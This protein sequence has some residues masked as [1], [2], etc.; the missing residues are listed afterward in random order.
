[1]MNP[2]LWLFNNVIG[3]YMFF[4]IVQA[5]LSL[6]IMFNIVNRYQPFVQQVSVFLSGITEPAYRRIRR[7]V[8]QIANMGGFDL[9]PMLLYVALQFVQ[10]SVNWAWLSI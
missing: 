3:I 4:I 2:I 8:P 5:I 6:L 9:S 10:Y 7:Y 1:M